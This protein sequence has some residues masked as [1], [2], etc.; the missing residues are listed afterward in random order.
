MSSV[1]DGDISVGIATQ[2]KWVCEVNNHLR[3]G[4]SGD[5]STPPD[6]SIADLRSGPICDL[7][8]KGLREKPSVRMLR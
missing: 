7:G 4:G 5:F 3:K 6:T 8:V 1:V 2:S